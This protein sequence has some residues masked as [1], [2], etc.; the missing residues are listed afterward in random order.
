MTI[1]G[2][3]DAVVG[4]G[5]VEIL[6]ARLSGSGD[7]TVA[8][9]ADTADLQASGG[10][11]IKVA[12]VNGEVHKS[13]SGGSSIN[14]YNSDV[15]EF[16]LGKLAQLAA[17]TDDDD[18]S[19]D[20]VIHTHRTSHGGGSGALHFFAG[21]AVLFILYA[22]WRTIQRNGGIGPL[23]ARFNRGPGA[24]PAPSH[25]GVI[26]VRDTITR[27]E[28]RLARVE[29]YVTTREFDLQRKFREL[30]KT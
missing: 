28:G 13:A 11:D 9:T 24:P 17:T 4:K 22:I 14:I 21:L 1:D 27:L 26:A 23:Q 18:S 5:H 16:G 20:S 25:P 7:L 15:A 12:H 10:G 8:A 6:H 2:S 29:N 30:D 19:S 3:G